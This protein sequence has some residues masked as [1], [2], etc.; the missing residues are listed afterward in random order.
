MLE[1][2][3][4]GFPGHQTAIYRDGYCLRQQCHDDVLVYEDFTKITGGSTDD[5]A[6]GEEG[7]SKKRLNQ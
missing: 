1:P 4:A 3:C 7:M 6:A 2:V 5:T